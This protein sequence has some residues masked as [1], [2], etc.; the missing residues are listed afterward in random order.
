MLNRTFQAVV[1]NA[2]SRCN[3]T[4]EDV[5]NVNDMFIVKYD[6]TDGGAQHGEGEEEEE[7]WRR[8]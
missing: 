2:V 1:K 6:A 3:L 4:Q 7:E 8:V 5:F